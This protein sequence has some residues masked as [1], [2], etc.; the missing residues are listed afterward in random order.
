MGYEHSRGFQVSLIVYFLPIQ[1][2]YVL[3]SVSSTTRLMWK[4]SQKRKK[5][6]FWLNAMGKVLIL[7]VQ[8]MRLLRAEMLKKPHHVV[9]NNSMDE[10]TATTV[11]NSAND[12]ELKLQIEAPPAMRS[13]CL[14]KSYSTGDKNESSLPVE[15]VADAIEAD[16][17]CHRETSSEETIGS[18][19]V[20]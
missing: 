5:N 9:D 17:L 15:G 3:F 19:V 14:R 18:L 12:F 2:W 4:N 20:W 6:P 1:C 8:Y 7:S 10:A 13:S 11:V 16:I